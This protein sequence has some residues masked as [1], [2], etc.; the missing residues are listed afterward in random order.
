MGYFTPQGDYVPRTLIGPR[1][2]HDKAVRLGYL[3]SVGLASLLAL[4]AVAPFAWMLITSVRPAG[5]IFVFPA[6]LWPSE[7]HFSTYAEALKRVPFLRYLGNSLFTCLSAVALQLLLS[8]CAAYALSR[9]KPRYGKFILFMIVATLMIPF[10][11]LVIPLYMQMRSFPF[12]AGPG[13]NLLNT[14]WVLILPA[15]VSAFNVFVLKGF[16]DRLPEEVI[17]TARLDGCTEWAIFFKFVLPMSRPILTVLGIFG[18][19]SVWNG[20]FWPLV[21]LNDP[22]IYT[23][24]LG[25]Q[26]LLETGEPWN[27]VMAAVALTTVPTIVLF[28][29]FQRWIMRG[30][31]F[32]GLQG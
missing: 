31:A 30:M 22:E 18:F 10:E 2:R 23:L 19:I 9:L 28:L 8:A 27:I 15:V 32:S 12:G 3:A 25:I 4:A 7:F 21:A 20:F 14:Y 26:K 6:R 13:V 24:M 1:E 16:F 11:S 5:E 29:F 17:F